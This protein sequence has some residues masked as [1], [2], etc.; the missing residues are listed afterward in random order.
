MVIINEMR[1]IVE[2]IT[3]SGMTQE[4]ARNCMFGENISGT[5]K[6]SLGIVEKINLTLALKRR[7]EIMRYII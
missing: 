1:T 7:D 3:V 2:K 4:R 6:E 5:S